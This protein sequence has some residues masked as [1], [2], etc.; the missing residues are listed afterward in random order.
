MTFNDAILSNFI[1]FQTDFTATMQ[2]A[3][4]AW[5]ADAG[6]LQLGMPG[7]NVSL[8]IG[9]EHIIRCRN[10]TGST[11]TNGSLVYVTGAS[12][13]KP[14]IALADAD[15]EA[16][17]DT[18][19]GMATEDINN[20]S[21][22]Y[23]TERG[24]VRDLD[25]S[26]YAEGTILYLS[27]TA[28]AYT[29][30][31]PTPPAHVVTAGVVTRQH[32]TEGEILVSINIGGDLASLHDVLLT[33]LSN[34]DILSY[35]SG[36]SYWKNITPATLI[37]NYLSGG[38][39]ISYASGVISADI[40]TT[41][42][43][44]TTGQINTI[45]DI[46]TGASPTFVTATFSSL[47]GVDGD[48]LTTDAGGNLGLAPLS[49]NAVTAL[50]GTANQV[51]VNGFTG[52]DLQGSLTL[53][54]PQSIG[55]TSDVLFNK[56]TT[57]NVS[58]YYIKKSDGSEAQILYLD[59]DTSN[60]LYISSTDIAGNIY[61]Q[62][63]SS[64]F[65]HGSLL[66]NGSWIFGAIT[67]SGGKVNSLATT[68]Q[69]RLSYDASNY[70]S[71]TVSSGGDLTITPSGGDITFS[72]NIGIGTAPATNT[73]LDIVQ[74]VDDL[75]IA[76]FKA[77][78]GRGAIHMSASGQMVI[79]GVSAGFDYYVNT[80][81]LAMRISSGGNVSA[82]ISTTSDARFHAVSVTEQLRLGYDASNYAAFTVSSGGDLTIAPSG[83]DI[84]LSAN[85]GI[86]ESSPDRQLVSAGTGSQIQFKKTPGS[87][88]GGYLTSN[89]DYQAVISGGAE[90][91]GTNWIARATETGLIQ[92]ASG[93]INFYCNTSQTVGNTATLTE[94]MRIAA[95]GNVGIGT[96]API[97]AAHIRAGADTL[98]SLLIDHEYNKNGGGDY[99]NERRDLFVGP[100]LSIGGARYGAANYIGMNANLT[101]SSVAGATNK[102][103]PVY[104]GSGA[105]QSMIYWL[106][107]GSGDMGIYTR[108]H[109]TDNTAQP[110]SAFTSAIYI[111]A[112]SGNVGIGD[113]SPDFRMDFGSTGGA[114]I[115]AVYSNGSGGDFYGFGISAGFLDIYAGN[116][117]AVTVASTT[118][119]V[120]IT[121]SIS[122]G[123]GSF[124]IPHPDP[125]KQKDNWRLR[126]YFVESNTAGDTFYRWTVKTKN[127]K[128]KIKLPSYFKFLNTNAQ[129]WISPVKHFGVAYGVILKDKETLRIDSNTDGVYNVL[130]VGTRCDEIAQKD[131]D[132]YGIEYQT[133][134]VN[135]ATQ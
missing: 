135:A 126:H 106:G 4:L 46:G 107:G 124:D 22:G 17:A 103:T 11:I 51:L 48:F 44:F 127:G 8:Q 76:L 20:N 26:S 57:A 47:T 83:G 55:T 24:I 33:S 81:T 105:T 92:I 45:Q 108:A 97:A 94:H 109:G 9:Q 41:N 52:V 34:N 1:D 37:N 36:N 21:N 120:A 65:S 68:E 96:S 54:L 82:G 10:V 123:S 72:A 99:T 2:E 78:S 100:Y 35:D 89:A 38:D 113:S 63:A 129:V 73:P 88:D 31:A 64:P 15:T 3:R 131:F 114:K 121:G 53:T 6:T 19:I 90:F 13:N 14:T 79:Q 70:T 18:I 101:Y 32:A 30:T 23:V 84:T 74:S 118:G 112:S 42:L 104:A 71:F 66:A 111:Q 134:V 62:N 29:D 95:S 50:T 67:S 117:K 119:N 58:G 130:V 28:G 128:A 133:E 77:G 25:T 59:N 125:E 12:G 61:F 115:L 132:K 116:T 56:V 69:L 27:Q 122:K 40:N 39:G 80:S 60:N 7:G 110:L 85:V 102:W 91:D 98:P 87:N 86:G 75:G 93:F 5:D 49:A 43:K 16:T